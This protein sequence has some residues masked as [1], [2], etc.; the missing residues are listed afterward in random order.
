VSATSTDGTA[1]CTAGSQFD[2]AAGQ[3][4]ETTV[5]L[6]CQTVAVADE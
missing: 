6:R 4:T 1:S 5:F 3:T 2:V